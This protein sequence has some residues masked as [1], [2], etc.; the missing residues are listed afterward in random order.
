M[1]NCT[2]DLDGIKKLVAGNNCWPRKDLEFAVTK[3]N[4]FEIHSC[5]VWIVIIIL[6]R[7]VSVNGL[8]L[9]NENR[10]KLYR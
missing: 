3:I 9:N 10:L 1:N 6:F 7:V 4:T 8:S 2:D 5:E